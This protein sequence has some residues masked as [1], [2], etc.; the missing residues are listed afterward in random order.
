MTLCCAVVPEV[1]RYGGCSPCAASEY[2]FL[3]R[4]S[5][6]RRLWRLALWLRTRLLVSS[7]WLSASCRLPELLQLKQQLQAEG[8]CY[9]SVFMT[10]SGS[11]I[12]CVGS[13]GACLH[14]ADGSRV[15]W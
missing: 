14:R 10:G 4:R 2:A 6:R 3:N 8:S 7:C 9:S 13:G 5:P 12:V 1:L 15:A 11:T